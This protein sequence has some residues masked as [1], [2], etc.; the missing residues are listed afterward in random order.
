MSFPF[1]VNFSFNDGE[2]DD[3]VDS[4]SSSR[5]A[6]STKASCSTISYFEDITTTRQV[7]DEVRIIFIF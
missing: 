2:D 6:S 7:I 3:F 4:F 1:P 5:T